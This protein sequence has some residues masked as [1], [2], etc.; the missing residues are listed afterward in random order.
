MAMQER[1]LFYQEVDVEDNIELDYLSDRLNLMDLETADTFKIGAATEFR[2][3][4]VSQYFYGSYHYGWLIAQH[5]DM[6]D[7]VK[8]FT[9]G[10]TI[11][12]P[13]L[14]SY[15]RFYHRNARRV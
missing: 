5:N 13:S 12:I 11:L 6:L 7:P 10:K 3:D 4:L 2:P 1:K 8:E 14:D 9:R 15:Y